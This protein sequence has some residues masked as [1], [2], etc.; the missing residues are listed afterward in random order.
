MIKKILD[1]LFLRQVETLSCG[2]NLNPKKVTKRT[3]IRHKKLLT[4][5]CLHK[6]NVLRIISNDDMSST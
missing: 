3:Q 1:I 5:I 2:R 4:E 6:G